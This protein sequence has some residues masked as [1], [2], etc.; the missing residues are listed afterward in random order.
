MS[1]PVDPGGAGVAALAGSAV[2]ERLSTTN[3]PLPPNLGSSERRGTRMGK[4]KGK[5]RHIAA[6]YRHVKQ[7]PLR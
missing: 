3:A 5:G 1:Y 2:R 4:R 7:H 6:L